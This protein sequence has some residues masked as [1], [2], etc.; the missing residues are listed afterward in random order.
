MLRDLES[1]ARADQDQ[2]LQR[3]NRLVFPHAFAEES[4]LWPEGADCCPTVRN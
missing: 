3:I 2:V 4:V 1:A